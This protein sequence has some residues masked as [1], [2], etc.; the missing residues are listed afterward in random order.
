MQAI[1]TAL[2]AL[3]VGEA[4]HFRNLTAFPLLHPAAGAP[5][6]LTLSEAVQRKTAQITEVSEAGSVQQLLL[7]NRGDE[8]VL[9]LD[10]E[11]L[12][13][14][15]QNRIA[16]LTLLAAPHS[17]TLLPVSCVE[18]GR[19]AWRTS[20]FAVSERTMFARGRAAKLQAVNRN[21]KATGTYGADQS[22]VW[23]NIGAKFSRM[24]L[25]SPT[26]AM[27]DMFE[28]HRTRIEDYAAMIRPVAQQVGVLFAIDGAIEG[29]DLFDAPSTLSTMLPKLARSFAVDA[30]ETDSDADTETPPAEGTAALQF[31]DRIAAA[32]TDT[33]PAIGLG[34]DVRFDAPQVAG[35]GLVKD[36]RLVHL[37][38]FA[39][40]VGGAQGGTRGS[41]LQSA[42]YDWMRG[43]GRNQDG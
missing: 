16:N 29:M 20:D 38:A 34:T 30:L 3:S 40:R 10:G 35:S 24:N 8:K 1:T 18:Q 7:D 31:L 19:W 32:H 21:L 26:A 5:D 36:A 43:R 37:A 41:R 39:T 42:R 15:K 9:I 14:A 22:E 25:E 12:I 13:G 6:Y 33:Y 11:E 23:D 17:K 28:H 4:Q 27:S 2:A